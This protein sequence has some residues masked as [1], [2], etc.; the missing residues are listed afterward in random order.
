MMQALYPGNNHNVAQYLYV[1]GIA[2]VR[3]EDNKNALDYYERALEM[4]QALYPYNHPEVANSLYILGVVYERLGDNEKALDYYKKTL[5]MRQALHKGNHPDVAGSLYAMGVIHSRLK[6]NNKALDYL[7][8][9]L[10]MAQALYQDNH[11]DVATSLNSVGVVYGSL[12]DNRK[13]LDCYERA[14]K[15]RQTLY[16]YQDNH[17]EVANSL[18]AVGVAY[19]ALG[20]VMKGLEYQEQSLNMRQALYPDGHPDTAQS[21]NSLG[22]V[23]QALG[24]VRK[25]LDY[26]K[27]A[28]RMRHTLYKGNHPDVA[29]SLNNVGL[30]YK[31]LGDGRKGLNYQ[32]QALKMRQDLYQ[33][34]HPDIANSLNNVGLAYQALGDVRKGL[35]YHEQALKMRQALYKGD[36]PD[37]AASLKNVGIAYKKLGDKIAHDDYQKR[38]KNM[39]QALA[40]IKEKEFKGQGSSYAINS[41]FEYY[42]GALDQILGLRLGRIDYNGGIVVLHSRCFEKDFATEKLTH[43]ATVIL[44]SSNAQT[45]VAPINFYNSHWVGLSFKRLGAK[46]EVTYMDSEQRAIIPQLKEGLERGLSVN[47]YGS[48]FSELRLEMQRYNNCGLEVIENFVYYLTGARAMQETAVYVHSLLV[49]NNLLDSKEYGLK[50]AENNK[51]IEFLSNAAP[52]TIRSINPLPMIEKLSP[53]SSSSRSGDPGINN[54]LRRRYPFISLPTS[55]KIVPPSGEL[56]IARSPLCEDD[57]GGGVLAEDGLPASRSSESV[58]WP[59]AANNDELAVNL[60][61]AIEQFNR[62]W[63]KWVQ[64]KIIQVNSV[65]YK[66]TLGFKGLDLIVDSARLAYEPEIDNAKKVA[67]DASQLYGMVVGVNGY[68]TLVSGAE[69]AYQL[70]LGEYQKACDVAIGASSAMVLPAILAIVNRPYLGFIYG[71][72]VAA[73]TAYDA[74]ENAYSFALELELIASQMPGGESNDAMRFEDL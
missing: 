62:L 72:W 53:H 31:A 56:F 59:R 58:V 73:S 50:I 54:F 68:S 60:L 40:Q 18:Y 33:G 17:P 57:A 55:I 41:L 66:T 23:Y 8:Q 47:G 67:Y 21:L 36:H 63:A 15:I 48:K 29:T 64:D 46:I 43:D 7:E 35:D 42:N 16:Q 24:D 27:Q 6:D 30:A 37:V 12:G 71:A 10:K 3:L 9:S 4:R 19:E 34:N 52:I 70:H 69:V 61:P 20:D 22:I 38:S 13:A 32:E 25:G 14:L 74:L 26:K 1:V 44:S 65:I 28:L 49:E 2:Y 45:V 5:D 39:Y 51:L 11:P